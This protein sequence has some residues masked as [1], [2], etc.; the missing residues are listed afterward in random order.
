MGQVDL[1]THTIKIA[2]RERKAHVNLTI[3]RDTML[4]ADSFDSAADFERPEQFAAYVREFERTRGDVYVLTVTAHF[5][6]MEGWDRLGGCEIGDS[7]EDVETCVRDH[8]MVTEALKDLAA[9]VE[10]LLTKLK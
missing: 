9:N 3:E 5:G 8:G 4:P 10:S 2:G 7:Y 6:G 1:G